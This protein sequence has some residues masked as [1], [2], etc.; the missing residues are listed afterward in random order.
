MKIIGTAAGHGRVLVD[1]DID[2]LVKLTGYKSNYYRKYENKRELGVGDEVNVDLL[3]NHFIHMKT[4]SEK[5][6]SAKGILDAVSG[7]LTL[8]DNVIQKAMDKPEVQ[9]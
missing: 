9:E 5:I 7:G 8:A 2:E 4:V 1:A 3:Y 6:N